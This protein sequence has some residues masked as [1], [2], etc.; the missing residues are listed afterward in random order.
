ML[1]NSGGKAGWNRYAINGQEVN[2]PA[3]PSFKLFDAVSISASSVVLGT[4]QGIKRFI[5]TQA[6]LD[7]LS[8]EFALHLEW[9]EANERVVYATGSHLKACTLPSF[10][11]VEYYLIPPNPQDIVLLYNK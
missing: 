8:P 9:D 11:Q 6:S 5:N 10:Q 7:D 3:L 4:D 2:M 1:Y